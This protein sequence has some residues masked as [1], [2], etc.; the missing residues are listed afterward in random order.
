LERGNLFLNHVFLSKNI[1]H[2][3]VVLLGT[4]PASNASF[5][6]SL[7]VESIFLGWEKSRIFKTL[8]LLFGI[9]FS[10]PVFSRQ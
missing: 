7:S 5:R 8:V 1:H 4:T 2:L 10:P 9:S 3:S 6:V